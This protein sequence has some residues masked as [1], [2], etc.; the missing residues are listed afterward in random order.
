MIA[1]DSADAMAATRRHIESGWLELLEFME[2][3]EEPKNHSA[4]KKRRAGLLPT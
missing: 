3:E 4:G 2:K 1:G